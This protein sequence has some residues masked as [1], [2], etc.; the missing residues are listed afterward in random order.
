MTDP[1]YICDTATGEMKPI[2]SI[3]DVFVTPEEPLFSEPLADLVREVTGEIKAELGGFRYD[4]KPGKYRH[5]DLRDKDILLTKQ[6]WIMVYLLKGNDLY[7]RFPKK[8]RRSSTMRHYREFRRARVMKFDN[9]ILW[10]RILRR[11]E[12]NK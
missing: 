6:G 3:N 8:I 4:A 10:E 7:V 9:R 11:K 1:I 5:I 2:S 12:T